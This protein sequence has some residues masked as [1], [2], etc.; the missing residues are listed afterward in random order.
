M[1]GRDFHCGSPPENAGQVIRTAECSGNCQHH[2]ADLSSEGSP[3]IIGFSADRSL[4]QH[5]IDWVS[6]FAEQGI[7]KYEDQQMSF[8][9]CP[10]I[11]R[12]DLP[13]NGKHFPVGQIRAQQNAFFC[14]DGEGIHSSGKPGNL[15]QKTEKPPAVIFVGKMGQGS[16]SAPQCDLIC[17][18]FHQYHL[19]ITMYGTSYAKPAEREQKKPAQLCRL[20]G[21]IIG[22]GCGC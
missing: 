20:K 14:D 12:P 6:V 4:Q 3:A 9:V 5:I 16:E 21:N 18:M 19:K 15:Q 22:Y 17:R 2:I 1:A 7:G 11:V 13:G 8:S 10:D